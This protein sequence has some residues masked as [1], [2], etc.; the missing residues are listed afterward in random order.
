MEGSIRDARR[1]GIHV[2]ANAATIN[3]KAAATSDETS[4]GLTSYNIP[5]SNR[6][7]KIAANSPDSNS[8][9]NQTRTLL[10]NPAHNLALTCAE[11]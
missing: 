2:A 4:S 9:Q 1:A 11:C 7:N 3:A 6:V 10:C 5:V 8:K